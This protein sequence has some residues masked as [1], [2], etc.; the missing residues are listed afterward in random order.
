[1]AHAVSLSEDS[2]DDL[3]YAARAPDIDFLKES[4]TEL[5]SHH[6]ASELDIVAA[7]I[8]AQTGNGLAHYAAANGCMGKPSHSSRLQARPYSPLL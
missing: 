6:Q 7:A 8:D 2:I 3:L 1:M 4:L 5:S